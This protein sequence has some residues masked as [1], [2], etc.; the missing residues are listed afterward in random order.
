MFKI[1]LNI[2]LKLI[3]GLAAAFIYLGAGTVS[4]GQGNG[5]SLGLTV[6]NYPNPFDS[7]NGFTT[8]VYSFSKEGRGRMLIYDL[9]G[10]LVKE[11]PIENSG[12]GA[13]KLVW[14]GTNEAGQKVAKGGYVCVVEV[15]TS[16]NKVLSIRKIGVI[17]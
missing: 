13:N 12:T 1:K 17:H 3:L 5:N 15:L 16:S 14:D 8:I 9:L 7:R 11:Y 10:N 6:S 4:F 2:I